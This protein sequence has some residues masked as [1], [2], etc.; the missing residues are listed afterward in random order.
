MSISLLELA[1]EALGPLLADVMFVGGASVALWISDPAAPPPRPTKDVDIVAEITSLLEYEQ[2]SRR[3]RA[4]GFTEDLESE[5]I[6][7]WRHA[8]SDLLLDAMP[9]DARLLGFSNRWQAAA[10]PHAVPRQLPSGV[11]LRAIT[12]PHL[13][14]TKLEAFASR[15]R[16]DLLGSRDFADVI[17]LVDGRGELVDEIGFA[18]AEVRSYVA[19]QIADL[20]ARPHVSE[21]VAGTLLPDAASQARVE[22][23]VLPRL[24]RIAALLVDPAR[25][26][27]DVDELLDPRL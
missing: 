1:A 21:G 3:M 15:G 10:L 7:R 27:A 26:R 9:T 2:F 18:P 14:A 25:L 5:V 16:G 8:A 22:L 6:C 23:I 11:E 12:P 24:R 13:V 20:L 19:E 17:G 4:Q